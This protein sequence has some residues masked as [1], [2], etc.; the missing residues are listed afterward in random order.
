MLEWKS[1]Y[2][3]RDRNSYGAEEATATSGLKVLAVLPSFYGWTGDAVNERQLTLALSRYVKSVYVLT[4]IGL[5]QLVTRRRSE[6]KVSV[7]EN[8]RVLPLLC[9]YLPPPLGLFEIVL[10]SYV[11]S[12]FAMILKILRIVDS[13]YVRNSLL[14]FGFV[15]I[16]NLAKVTVVKLPALVE[17]ELLPTIGG[18]LSKVVVKLCE[19]ADK[20][21]VAKAGRVCVPS[22]AFRQQL[23]A[24]RGLYIRTP[25]FVIS[26]GVDV[27]KM[28]SMKPDD[29][30][31]SRS[32]T[33]IGFIGSLSWWQGVD[34]LVESMAI[35][36]RQFPEAHLF[37]VG[38]GKM[39]EMLEQ[40][41]RSL[42]VRCTL[43]G[44]IHHEDAV[45]LLATF[46]ILVSPGR[47]TS[48][49]ESN[50]PIKLIEAWALGVPV[51]VTKHKIL[52]GRFKDREDLIFCEPE[53]KDI[54]DEILLALTN[55]EMINRLAGRSTLLAE[56]FD[57]EHIASKLL[58]ALNELKRKTS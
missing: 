11:V 29:Q 39:S 18:Q 50:I 4:L 38:G 47:R 56:E 5:K 42:K 15:S 19:T 36:N 14:A 17:D 37:I 20:L 54:A 23:I 40:K 6:L 45:K 49:T 52:D 31:F 27:K 10:A 2:R 34:L 13:I 16:K 24:R 32:E 41:C 33:R 35:V 51:I 9:P 57:Y 53:V 43:T 28:R 21:V 22:G 8:M 46:Y 25:V 48:T 3:L 1:E 30:A 58:E 12:L 26:P 44:L 7:P 55:P